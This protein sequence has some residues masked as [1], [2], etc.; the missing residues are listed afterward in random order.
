M[1]LCEK[2]TMTHFQPAVN[3]LHMVVMEAWQ[4]S[5]LLSF[6]VVRETDLASVHRD[7]TL[8]T[9]SDYNTL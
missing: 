6:L 2:G 9:I 4:Y 1:R 5:Q 7:E 3:A 8:P